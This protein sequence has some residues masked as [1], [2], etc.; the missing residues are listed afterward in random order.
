MHPALE[1]LDSHV[2]T[3]DIE[4]NPAPPSLSSLLFS[5]PLLSEPKR[6]LPRSKAR[7]SSYATLGSPT[8]CD[9]PG[10]IILD[11]APRPLVPCEKPCFSGIFNHTD[12]STRWFNFNCCMPGQTYV[13]A[14]TD[15]S[16]LSV[17][18]GEFHPRRYDVNDFPT[19]AAEE[20]ASRNGMELEPN[21]ERIPVCRADDDNDH[22]VNPPSLSC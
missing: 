13:H 10:I 14:G 5:S 17:V 6:L 7:R 12:R 18:E 22:A 4:K 3:F 1:L 2:L 9:G 21:S 8:V 15:A 19:S 20:L 11:P 16:T